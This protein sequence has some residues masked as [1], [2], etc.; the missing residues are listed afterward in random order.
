[1]S[2]Q[3]LLITE[4]LCTVYEQSMPNRTD[5]EALLVDDKTKGRNVSGRLKR[6]SAHQQAMWGSKGVICDYD[7]LTF[8]ADIENGQFIKA[9]DGRL[10]RVVSVGNQYGGK[11]GIPTHINYLLQQVRRR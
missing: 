5:S 2:L 3:A 10:F 8:D 6:Q 9:A 7:F 1:M 11:G 4:P